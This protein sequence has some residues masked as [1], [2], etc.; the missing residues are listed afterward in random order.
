MTVKETR[1]TQ[2]YVP[3]NNEK[4]IKKAVT[5]NVDSIILDL[6]DSVPLD[7]KEEARNTISKLLKEIDFGN[8]EICVRINSIGNIEGLKDLVFLYKE[9]KIDCIVVPKSEGELDKV[10]FATNKAI[11]ALVETAKGLLNIENMLNAEGVVAVTWG[12]ADLSFSV[13]GKEERYA[14]NEFVRTKIVL[15]AKHFGIDAIDKVYFNLSDL[16]GF[17]N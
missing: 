8:K 7:Y 13:G 1:R 11:I 4:M 15:A 17:K 14:K 10:H 3:G 9:D 12:S 6:E 2:I 16:E 5:F